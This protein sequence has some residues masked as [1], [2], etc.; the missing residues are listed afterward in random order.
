M[1]YGAGFV[2]AIVIALTGVGAGTITAPLLILGLRIPP[3]IA[4]GTA[5]AYSAVVKLIIVPVQML[6]RQVNYRVLAFMLAGGLPGVIAGSLLLR[7]VAHRGRW[8]SLYWVLGGIIVFSSAWHIFRHFWPPAPSRVPRQRLSW[9]AAIM[10]PIGAEVGFSSSGA[11]ALGTVA[12]MS[13]TSLP[14]AQIVGTDLTFGLALSLVGGGIH[15]LNG[16][17]NL[18]LLAKMSGGGLV[19]AVVGTSIAPRLPN[20]LLRLALSACLLVIGCIFFYRAAGF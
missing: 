5:L 18:A 9:I 12:L 8:A 10:V 7:S 2:I 17:Y 13:L 16:L 14:A 6:R 19:G 1:E 15:A 4:V 11:G 3:G 20:R